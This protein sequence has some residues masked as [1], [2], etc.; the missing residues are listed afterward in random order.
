MIVPSMPTRLLLLCA[1]ALLFTLGA[2]DNPP[3]DP[4]Q[5]VQTAAYLWT[6]GLAASDPSRFKP[7]LT[8]AYPLYSQ[9]DR[10]HDA[11]IKT[12]FYINPVMPQRGEHEYDLLTG[13]YADV[14][15]KDCSGNASTSYAG[16]GLLSDPRSPRAADFYADTVDWYIHHKIDIHGGEQNPNAL[17]VDNNGALYGVNPQ[18]CN[19]DARSWGRAFD[20]AIAGIHQPIVTNSLAARDSDTA[21]YVDRL[22]PPNIIGGMFE[23]CFND[24]LWS[25]EE[26]SQIETI[27]LFKRE[28][29][30]SGPGWWCYVN[31]TSADGAASIPQRLF[32]YA[33][34]LLTYDP[35][36]STFQESFTTPSKFDVFPETGFV[37]LDPSSNPRNVEDLRTSTGA[38]VQSYSACYYRGRRIGRCEIAVNPGS[39]SVGVPNRGGLHHSMVIQGEGVLDGGSVAFNGASVG[40]LGAQSAAILVP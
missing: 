16:K 27:A 12:I 35:K 11:G 34:F 25:A 7:Y 21:T 10:V 23:E 20:R 37:P 8:W 18:P 29:K 39:A 36:Y 6:P 40:S 14:G 38:Y 30:S 13:Q 26:D 5:H 28:H 1:A 24:R 19:Y 2:Y 3:S 33:S 31:N 22:T 32:A 9:A 15:A 17:F 4:P